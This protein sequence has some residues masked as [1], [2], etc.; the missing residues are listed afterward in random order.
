M[1]ELV[2]DFCSAPRPRFVCPARDFDSGIPDLEMGGL[3]MGS[4]GGWVAC[5]PCAGMV[6]NGQRDRLLRVAVRSIATKLLSQGFGLPPGQAATAEA[7]VRDLHDVFWQHREGPPRLLTYEERRELESIPEREVA[8][9]DRPRRPTPAW[10]SD[11]MR[12][13]GVP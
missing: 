12:A 9:T 7:G 3:P 10:V 2:C 1:R 5:E 13:P 4:V 6:R 8:W 11:L